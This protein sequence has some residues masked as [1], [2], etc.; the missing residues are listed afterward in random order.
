MRDCRRLKTCRIPRNGIMSNVYKK[1][2]VLDIE[3]CFPHPPLRGPPSPEGKV[4]SLPLGEAGRRSLTDEGRRQASILPHLNKSNYVRP[5]ATH[6]T[7]WSTDAWFPSSTAS[8]SPFPGGEGILYANRGAAFWPPLG[9]GYLTISQRSRSRH[10]RHRRRC[11]SC[12]SCHCSR[13][14][15]RPAG[16]RPAG[17]ASRKPCRRPSG[18]PRWRP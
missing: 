17:R 16:E 11:R 7:P 5:I 10:P 6:R 3:A 14:P 2:N 9:L 13:S 15:G 4:L 1:C 8:R 18:L 12:R